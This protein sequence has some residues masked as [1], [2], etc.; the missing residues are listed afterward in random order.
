MEPWLAREAWAMRRF[1][2]NSGYDPEASYQAATPAGSAWWGE[3]LEK[4]AQDPSTGPGYGPKGAFMPIG[5][6]SVSCS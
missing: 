4:R 6:M 5:L 2:R 1:E 3:S